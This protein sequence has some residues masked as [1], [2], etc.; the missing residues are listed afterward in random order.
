MAHFEIVPPGLAVG[1]VASL[2]PNN[3]CDGCGKTDEGIG[4]FAK[5]YRLNELRRGRPDPGN[6]CGSC[7]G[8]QSGVRIA[9][10]II[11]KDSVSE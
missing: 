2:M 11:A 9:D 8:S 4:W 1:R 10:E 6:L 7:A 3:T 5:A